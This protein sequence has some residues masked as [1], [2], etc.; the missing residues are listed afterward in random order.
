MNRLTGDATALD[1][2]D[3]RILRALATAARMTTAELARQVGL[4]PPSTAERVRRLEDRGVITGYRA[5][6]AAPAIGL[7]L[8]AWLRIRPVPGAL[9]TVAEII[10]NIPEIVECDRVTGDDCFV[11]R[12][13]L[14]SVE[15]LERVIDRIIPY[16]MTNT[17]LIQSS[18]VKRRLPPLPDR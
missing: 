3:V 1:S 17:A 6:I 8:A 4:S 18:P 9:N 15:D 13:H 11:A 14:R 7:P 5:E 16:A 12:V 10:E 2:V